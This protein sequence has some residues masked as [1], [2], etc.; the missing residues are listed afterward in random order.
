MKLELVWEGEASSVTVTEKI[1]AGWAVQSRERQ[2][3]VTSRVDGGTIVWDVAPWTSP[4]VTLEYT[5]VPPA[6]VRHTPVAFADGLF[7]TDSGSLARIESVSLAP[8]GISA[9][10]EGV[11]PG[12]GYRGCEDA[13]TLAYRPEFNAGGSW[14]IEE[15]SWT[16]GTNDHKKMFVRFDLSTVPSTY[17]LE[18]AE[19]CLY[20]FGERRWSLRYRHTVFAARLLRP[21]RE[22]T[23][24]DFDGRPAR[25]GEVTFASALYRQ[26]PWEMPGANGLTDMADVE[27]TAAVG[28]NWPEWVRFDVTESVRQFLDNPSENHGW[29]IAQDPARGI[30]EYF[31]YYVQGVFMY[32]SS[33]APEAHLR[34]MLILVPRS[35]GAQL[36]SASLR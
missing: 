21:W 36:D 17:P 16:G 35:A 27:T 11:F 24:T 1:P 33:E 23:A 18:R 2:K 9:F 32:K 15:G 30:P 19:L 26:A 12:P 29:K 4:G 28:G 8:A 3:G 7:R 10:Q 6:Y 22:G 14:H 34:P 5:V 20:A 25:E 31:I 13:H